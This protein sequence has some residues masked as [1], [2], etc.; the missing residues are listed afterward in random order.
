MPH[1]SWELPIAP[2]DDIVRLLGVKLINEELVETDQFDIS[3]K[4]G[5]SIDYEVLKN[6]F[7]IWAGFQLMNLENVNIFDSHN[8]TS[9]NY[10]VPHTTGRFRTIAWIPN[11]L[12]AEGEY[13]FHFSFFNHLT[14]RIHIYEKEVAHFS[15]FDDLNP[16]KINPR[17]RSPR[18]L[19]GLIKPLLHWDFI[20]LN[21]SFI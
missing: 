7:T 13:Y 11:Y 8:V 10:D 21:K 9:P 3:E 14:S 1:Q 5:I 19:N 17:G 12:L 16:R 6:G 18:N 2:G 15:I 20:A 4:I